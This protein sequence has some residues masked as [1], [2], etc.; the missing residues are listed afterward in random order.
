MGG[1]ATQ[2]AISIE[3]TLNEVKIIRPWIVG[4]FVAGNIDD[5][6]AAIDLII[7]DAVLEQRHSSQDACITVQAATT[8]FI[9]SPRLR[10]AT[11]DDP[12]ITAIIT[13]TH[14]M[15]IFD[16]RIVNAN[17]EV[18]GASSFADVDLNAT[19]YAGHGAISGIA[20]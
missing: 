20:P 11:D 16:L 15:Q 7:Q 6:G 2:S 5:S 4:E 12:G 3:D 1:D 14:A 13:A 8:G 10:S 18:D 9:L 19:T 17:G